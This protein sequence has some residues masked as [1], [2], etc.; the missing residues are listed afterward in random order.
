[1]R[2]GFATEHTTDHNGRSNGVQF[3]GPNSPALWSQAQTFDVP[4][5]F[6]LYHG[7]EALLR[8]G[9]ERSAREELHRF[10][11]R[12]EVNERERVA[13]LRSLAVLSEFEGDIGRAIE[14]LHEAWAL[15]QKIGLPTNA[16][17]SRAASESFTRGGGRSARRAQCAP[18]ECRS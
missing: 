2:E 5:I 12:A 8:G 4:N 7:V 13:Y 6:Y 14:H 1:M 10:A 17:R 15:A 3:S 9:D 18:E 16:G 11:E